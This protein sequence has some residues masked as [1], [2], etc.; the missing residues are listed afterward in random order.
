M[1]TPLQRVS[2][3]PLAPPSDP[4]LSRESLRQICE[5]YYHQI[6]PWLP[7]FRQVE[8]VALAMQSGD[9]RKH[10]DP[11]LQAVVAGASPYDVDLP[12]DHQRGFSWLQEYGSSMI[13]RAASLDNLRITLLLQFL[14][15]GNGRIADFWGLVTYPAQV[16]TRAGL[17]L[18][19]HHL[20]HEHRH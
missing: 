8:V 18:E 2:S 17:H 5:V 6:Q 9:P 12:L 20:N 14:L 13:L 1:V 16:A 7:F 3:K 11:V 4:D 19:D 15:F 10:P